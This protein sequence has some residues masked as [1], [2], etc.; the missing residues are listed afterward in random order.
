MEWSHLITRA[1]CGAERSRLRFKLGPIVSGTVQLEANR[2][3]VANY[4]SPLEGDIDRS[5]L[6]G[7]IAE[8]GTGIYLMELHFVP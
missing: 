7:Q 2:F 3:L 8:E 6:E 5:W 4:S 1:T